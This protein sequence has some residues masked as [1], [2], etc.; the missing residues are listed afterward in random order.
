MEDAVTELTNR[1]LMTV[2]PTTELADKLQLLLVFEVDWF[3]Y[4]LAA[5]V[6]TLGDFTEGCVAWN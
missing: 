2:D 1:L 6:V 4:L 5:D 3:A